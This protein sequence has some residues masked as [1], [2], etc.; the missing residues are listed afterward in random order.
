M[1]AAHEYSTPDSPDRKPMKQCVETILRM[2]AIRIFFS[3]PESHG[4]AK[5]VSASR[6]PS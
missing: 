3:A 6:S 4:H 2:P 1:R 5:A